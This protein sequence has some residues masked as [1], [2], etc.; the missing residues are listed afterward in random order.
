M[1]IKKYLSYNP[2]LLKSILLLVLAVSGNFV[3]NTL[4]CKTQYHMTNN[5][6]IKHLLLIF[7]VFFTLNFTT[8]ENENP[9]NQIKRALMI[10]I[11]Y[12]LFTKQN[13]TFTL[14]SV[15]LL[16]LTYIIDTFSIYFQKNSEDTQLEEIYRKENKDIADLLNKSKNY[17]FIIG[18]L[19]IIIGFCI[20]MQSKYKEYGN[21]FNFFTFIFGKIKCNSLS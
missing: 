11:C 4:S 17:S 20:Y 13:E 21:N 15:V 14:L 9:I 12:L 1:N 5:M 10:W 2:N 3:G 18:I 19:T 7:I 6:Y 16:V 8:T